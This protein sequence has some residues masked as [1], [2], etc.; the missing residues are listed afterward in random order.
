MKKIVA[1]L[2]ALV[3][4]VSSSVCAFAVSSPTG[5][6]KEDKYTVT[7]TVKQND[8][9]VAGAT[10]SIDGGI[11]VTTDSNGAYRIENITAGSHKLVITKDGV[12]ETVSFVE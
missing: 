9:V 4:A 6:Q 2:F 7:G 11:T 1:L 3:I 12:S 10:V 8:K 5:Q